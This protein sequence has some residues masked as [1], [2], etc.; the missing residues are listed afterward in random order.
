MI[1]NIKKAFIILFL[2]GNVFVG[3]S[4]QVTAQ[5]LPFMNKLESKLLVITKALQ[6]TIAKTITTIVICVF[7]F[8]SFSGRI[9]KGFGITVL[10]G[11]FFIMFAPQLADWLF[12][13]T[14]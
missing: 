2:F 8:M 7:G 9:N 10:A 13:G 6:G 1:Q 14:K 11:A 3:G 4:V 5:E 12:D